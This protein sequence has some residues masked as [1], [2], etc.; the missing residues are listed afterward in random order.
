MEAEENSTRDSEIG[1]LELASVIG[2]EGKDRD[3]TDCCFEFGVI[4]P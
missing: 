1:S 2:F 4:S 3:P